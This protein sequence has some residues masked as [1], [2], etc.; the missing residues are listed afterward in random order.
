MR[1]G[2]AAPFIVSQANLAV[3]RQLWG[4][5]LDRITTGNIGQAR[6]G[7]VTTASLGFL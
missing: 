7:R 4:W 6:K 5:S 2:Q 3:A 1:R